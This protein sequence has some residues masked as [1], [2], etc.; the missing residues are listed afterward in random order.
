[1]LNSLCFSRVIIKFQG[2]DIKKNQIFIHI[3]IFLQDLAFVVFRG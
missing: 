3:R 2:G 1:M